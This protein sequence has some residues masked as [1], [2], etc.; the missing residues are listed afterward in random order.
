M[1]AVFLSPLSHATGNRTTALRLVE[2]ISQLGCAPVDIID[3][4]QTDASEHL[5]KSLVAARLVVA[6]HAFRAGKLLLD[7]A[8]QGSSIA[9]HPLLIVVLGG[10]DINHDIAEAMEPERARVISS[11][12]AR[13]TAVVAFT[14]A[15]AERYR[16]FTGGMCAT[17]ACD[18]AAMY[19]KLRVIP[20]AVDVSALPEGGKPVEPVVSLRSSLG[21]ESTARIILLIASIRPVKD[22]LHL[23]A[24]FAQWKISDAD[25]N[26]VVCGPVLDEAIFGS[27]RDATGCSD[28]F[29]G[30]SPA[31]YGGKNGLWYHPP[32]SRDVLLQW[33]RTEVDI[34]VN[35]SISEGQCGALL[36]AMALGVPVV[37]RHNDGNASIIEHGVSG[38]LYRE[39]REAFAHCKALLADSDLRSSVVSGALAAISAK[40]GIES[41]AAAWGALLSDLGFC[42]TGHLCEDLEARCT[43]AASAPL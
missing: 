27:V 37:A 30:S 24:A 17:G 21:L 12:L 16:V 28:L 22:P 2:L 38:M 18:S 40:H 35:S 33:L 25:V 20:Q 32:V 34:V 7:L 14:D 29:D 1:S 41:E 26:L 43:M 11:I 13:A 39:P 36:E 5:R 31:G 42:R 19:R 10:T 23:A 15:M 4:A 3:A 9:T 8:S 6:V